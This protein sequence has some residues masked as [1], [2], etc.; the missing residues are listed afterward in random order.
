[1]EY[2]FPG[3]LA[4][5]VIARWHTF[6]PRADTA[7]PPLPSPAQLRHLLETAFFSS[8]ER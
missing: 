6:A 1:M 2:A 3:D 7:A 5:Q 8:F 4:D